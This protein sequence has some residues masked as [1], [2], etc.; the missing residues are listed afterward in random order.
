M[1]KK[2]RAAG[3]NVDPFRDSERTHVSEIN[4]VNEFFFSDSDNSIDL[5]SIYFDNDYPFPSIF[6]FSEDFKNYYSFGKN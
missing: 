4:S 6:Q 1:M 2:I 3:K 5:Q